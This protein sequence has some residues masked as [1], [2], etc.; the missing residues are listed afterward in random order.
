MLRDIFKA[1]N[2]LLDQCAHRFVQKTIIILVVKEIK[3][4]YHSAVYFSSL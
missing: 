1:F 2:L 3:K 4:S